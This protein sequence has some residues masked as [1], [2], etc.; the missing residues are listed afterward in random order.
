MRLRTTLSLSALTAWIVGI[1]CRS[2]IISNEYF[3]QLG[4]DVADTFV[5]LAGLWL[6]LDILIAPASSILYRFSRR[7]FPSF[8]SP[9]W[10]QEGILFFLVGNLLLGY[11]ILRRLL[12][13][14]S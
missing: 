7:F 8:A 3:G 6:S 1:V 10:I 9:E 2:I 12:G 5:V 4:E 11:L 13:P 14:Q